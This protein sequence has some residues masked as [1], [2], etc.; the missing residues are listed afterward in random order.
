[1]TPDMVP[2]AR[3]VAYLVGEQNRIVADSVKME[4]QQECE[5]HVGFI[6]LP[7]PPPYIM[8]SNSL[9]TTPEWREKCCNDMLRSYHFLNNHYH[10]DKMSLEEGELM[11]LN[12]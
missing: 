7:P 10:S 5:N 9:K 12:N 3:I 6:I 4:V 1:M 2:I 8:S 11:Y